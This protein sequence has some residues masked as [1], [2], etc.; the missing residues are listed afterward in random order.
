MSKS[1]NQSQKPNQRPEPQQVR[2]VQKAATAKVQDVP[3]ATNNALG[4]PN[5][6]WPAAVLIATAIVMWPAVHG[7]FVNWD[8]APF[9]YENKTVIKDLSWQS[10]KD[11]MTGTV[12]GSWTPLTILTFHLEYQFVKIEP[13]LYHFNN[14]WLHILNTGLVWLLVR[15]LG[16]NVFP[17]AIVALLFGIH[18]LRVESVAW[19][20]ERKDVLFAAFYLG[21]LVLYVKQMQKPMK[22]SL[23]II[24]MVLLTVCALLSKIQAV[25]LPLSMLCIDYLLGRKLN[26]SLVL[27]KWIYFALAF[28]TGAAGVYLLQQEGTLSAVNTAS[29]AVA[30]A[31]D[32]NLTQ[33]DRFF[34]GSYSYIVY[35][36]KWLIPYRMCALYPYPDKLDTLHY[37]SMPV[38]LTVLAGGFWAFIKGYRNLVFGLAFFTFNIIFLLQIVGAG[39]GYIADR[40]T[41]VGYLGLFYI[42][43]ASLQY[44]AKKRPDL[45]TSLSGT[46]LIYCL[47]MAFMTFQQIPV[48]KNG[49]ALWTQ[50]IG[51]YDRITTPLNNRAENYRKATEIPG[52]MDSAFN[53]YN[54]SIALKPNAVAL[55][56]RGLVYFTR[57]RQQ[58]ALND[59]LQAL[60]LDTARTM[61]AEV[62]C[63]M[64][65]VYGATKQF[66]LAKK[67]LDEGLKLDSSSTAGWRNRYLTHLDLRM[68][69]LALRD[70]DYYLLK[71][72]TSATAHVDRGVILRMLGRLPD[73]VASID[74]GIS[75][76]PNNGLFYF[77][78]SMVLDMMGNRNASREAALTAQKLGT[79]VAPELLR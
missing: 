4:M 67:S 46:A 38:A 9:I 35:L 64:G 7:L 55:N 21:A 10:F 76:A 29:A 75:M 50:V 47:I 69:D 27:E 28:A 19:A 34:I 60:T 13:F 65:G 74:K 73:A 70:V 17:A 12:I 31:S 54:K 52:S 56:A 40:F 77:H 36:I 26:M 3:R 25:S 32:T 8:D 15:R 78:K 23:Y 71:E 68:Y 6:F 61:R 16:L 39:Q 58:D 2:P 48:W 24:S 79:Q 33:V 22:Q 53:D 1:R 11:I 18:P 14:W 20:T 63:N 43:G 59:Y 49:I 30:V 42:I 57:G 45:N 41:Y 51:Y 66:E 72:P 37:L 5:W 62:L 44:L